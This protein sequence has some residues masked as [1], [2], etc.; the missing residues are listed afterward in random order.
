MPTLTGMPKL[1]LIESAVNCGICLSDE[2]KPLYTHG[3]HNVNSAIC[4]VC[5]ERLNPAICP[6]CREDLTSVEGTLSKSAANVT[7]KFEVHPFF[8]WLFAVNVTNCRFQSPFIYK[9][10][11]R[12]PPPSGC[13]VPINEQVMIHQ[14]PMLAV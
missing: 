14:P 10:D 4:K 7:K 12:A 1:R 2:K 11:D 8:I 9:K 13:G 3:N 6:F 5:A